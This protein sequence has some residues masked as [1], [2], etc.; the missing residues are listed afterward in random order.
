MN[1][2]ALECFER[3]KQLFSVNLTSAL[4]HMDKSVILETDASVGGCQVNRTL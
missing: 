1:D 4:P 3:M 2:K